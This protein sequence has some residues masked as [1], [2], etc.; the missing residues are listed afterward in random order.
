VS[1]FRGEARPSAAGLAARSVDD[2]LA[3]LASAE[4]VPGG[5]TA[6]ALAAALAAALVAMVGRVTA[7]REA[8]PGTSAA[9]ATESDALRVRLLALAAQDG[10]AY[11]AVIAARRLP[12]GEREAAVQAALGRATDVPLAVAA[13]SRDALALCDRI[14]ATARASALGDLAVAA[15]LA[16]AAL[17]AASI[18]ARANLAEMDTSFARTAEERLR[19]LDADARAIA[20]RVKTAIARSGQAG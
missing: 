3:A 2:V 11:T 18:T 17:D 1:V 19:A 14:T 9:I 13:A 12:T 20:E 16:R 5:G 10:D 15:V 8:E 6:T 7:R 4:P